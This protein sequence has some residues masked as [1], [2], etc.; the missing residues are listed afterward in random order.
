[1]KEILE[2]AATMLDVPVEELDDSLVRRLTNISHLCMMVGHHLHSAQ[3]VAAVVEAW[4][5]ETNTPL[6]LE[7]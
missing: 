1:M 7:E 2:Q 3:I 5:R 6:A 4:A